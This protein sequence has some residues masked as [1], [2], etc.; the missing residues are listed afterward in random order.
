M[1]TQ[2]FIV[3]SGC[4]ENLRVGYATSGRCRYAV[5]S[6]PDQPTGLIKCGRVRAAIKAARR[7]GDMVYDTR[8]EVVMTV[9]H[10][11]VAR[12]CSLACQIMLDPERSRI[13]SGQLPPE[14]EHAR[15]SYWHDGDPRQVQSVN[16][17][18][19]FRRRDNVPIAW[20][21]VEYGN[22]NDRKQYLPERPVPQ[23]GYAQTAAAAGPSTSDR[24]GPSGK[25]LYC[26]RCRRDGKTVSQPE[27]FALERVE[28]SEMTEQSSVA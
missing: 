22:I 14:P 16:L 13:R 8:C 17:F 23:A 25:D 5:H 19:W 1:C 27:L 24:R 4:E 6:S 26:D 3:Y 11:A 20:Q 21:D 28:P 12:Y 7:Q 2:H 9:N 15:L 18:A 10:E